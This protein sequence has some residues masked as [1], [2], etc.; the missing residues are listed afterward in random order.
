MLGLL[1]LL[2]WLGFSLARSLLPARS[3]EGE[4]GGAGFLCTYALHCFFCASSLLC[5]LVQHAGPILSLII[6][7]EAKSTLRKFLA[8]FLL[9]KAAM[10]GSGNLRSD[11]VQTNITPQSFQNLL[12]AQTESARLSQTCVKPA[13][14]YV[15]SS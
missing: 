15:C 1:G 3:G 2:G 14:C 4:R 11:M 10:C 7:T 8:M 12:E 9:P 13:L 5:E 6:E